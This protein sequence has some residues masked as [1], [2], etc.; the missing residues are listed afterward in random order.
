VFDGSGVDACLVAR[1]SNISKN[2]LRA[3]GSI[4]YCT[5]L[6]KES[7]LVCNCQVCQCTVSHLGTDRANDSIRLEEVKVVEEARIDKAVTNSS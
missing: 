6:N 5:L 4:T 7:V 2:S 3:R 1:L